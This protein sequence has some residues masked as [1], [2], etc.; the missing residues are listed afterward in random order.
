ML[1]FGEKVRVWENVRVGENV[2][3]GKECLE[4]QKKPVRSTYLLTFTYK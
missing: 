1:G 3:V 4:L 2:G